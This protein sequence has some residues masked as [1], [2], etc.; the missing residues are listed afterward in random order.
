MKKIVNIAIFA[1]GSGS[2]ARKIM[3]HF[4][5]SEVGRVVL[6]VCNKM[7]AGVIGV[8]YEFSVPV[9]FIDRKYFYESE[10]LLN[11]LGRYRTEFIALAGFLW[12][13]PDYLVRSFPGR[14]VN[15][16]PALLPKYGGHGMYGHHVHEAVKAA[17]ELESGLTIHYVNENYDEGNIIF[18]TTCRLLP[19]DTPEDIGRK[20]L[21]LEHEHY[22][23]V[24]ERLLL[25]L[26]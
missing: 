20:V 9:V 22:P 16:H 4:Q 6:V 2:N 25:N 7:N 14:I 11:V 18:Q 23:R 3:E 1:S 13:V 15:I 19:D 10:D 26:K 8:A 5:S 12:L 17:G 21:F 24:I